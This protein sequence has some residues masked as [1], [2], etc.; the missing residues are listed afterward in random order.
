MAN[1]KNYEELEKE[2]VLLNYII[3]AVSDGVYAVSTD[4][5]ILIYNKAFEKMEGIPRS[6]MIGQK[7]LDM[8]LLEFEN[9]QRY[10]IQKNAEPLCDQYMTYSTITGKKV[11]IVYNSYPFFYDGKLTA[12]ISIGRDKP[13]T[14]EL[15]TMILN[16][17]N[18]KKSNRIT[19]G[20]TYTLEDIVGSSAIIQTTLKETRRAAHNQSTI[21]LIG[22]TGTGKELLAQGIHNASTHCSRPFIAVNC[23]AIPD[24]LMESLMLGTVKGAFSGAIDSPGFF[25]QAED[26]TLF[27]DEINSLTVPLQA[28]LLRL[29]QDKI[30]RRLGDKKERKISCRI[31]SAS[32]QDLFAMARNGSFREDLLYRLTPIVLVVPP[33]RERTEDIPLLTNQFVS[34]YNVQFGLSIQ[35]IAP[36]LLDIFLRYSWPGNVRELEHVVESAMSMADDTELVLSKEHLPTFL[37]NRFMPKMDS[38]TFDEPTRKPLITMLRQYEKQCLENAL[39]LSTGNASQCA[40]NLG[41]SRQDLYYRLRRLG[42]KSGNNPLPE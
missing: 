16:S 31:I 34:Q 2:N 28:K 36:E 4:G 17:F 6:R 35:C 41:I 5:T 19:N 40:R 33:L 22:E 39:K 8:Y 23:A 27:L 1:K 21:M 13:S 12:V 25:E 29:L 18:T 42:I 38:P 37:R 24:T 32:N 26:G 11:D 30:V 20:T 3:N 7:D 9:F 15:I 10:A 14:N